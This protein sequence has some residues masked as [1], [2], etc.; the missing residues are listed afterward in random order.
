M[1]L[2]T[3]TSG[4]QATKRA[5]GDFLSDLG[6][7]DWWATLTFRDRTDEQ[8]RNG[9]TK[10]GS[11]YSASAWKAFIKA[12]NKSLFHKVAFVNAREY[13]KWRGVPHYHALIRGVG[14]ARRLDWMDWWWERYGM[15]RIKPYDAEKG[16]GW[17]ISKYVAKE[18]GEI[19]FSQGLTN[20][21]TCVSIETG[22]T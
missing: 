7:W 9:W 15:A 21:A 2:S 18:L 14:D 3:S 11:G 13:Q 16:A 20:A 8:I 19:N 1:E 6:P 17:Y 12:L 5:W 22:D 10:V 4:S